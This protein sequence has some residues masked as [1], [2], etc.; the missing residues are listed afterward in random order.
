MGHQS[1]E[2]CPKASEREPAMNDV[3][4]SVRSSARAIRKI[5]LSWVILPLFN[6]NSNR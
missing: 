3:G 2:G 1:V 6:Y 5:V 4:A